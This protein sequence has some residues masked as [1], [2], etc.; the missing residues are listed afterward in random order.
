MQ[1][2]ARTHAALTSRDI[3]K[4]TTKRQ[5]CYDHVVHWGTF[6]LQVHMSSVHYI[7]S[8]TYFTWQEFLQ[9]FLYTHKNT[10][11]RTHTDIYIYT[12]IHTNKTKKQTTK[13]TNKQ[14]K[15]THTHTHTYRHAIL[16]GRMVPEL[17]CNYCATIVSLP[18]SPFTPE[19]Q[20]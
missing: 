9:I 15:T 18:L 1:G 16:L 13:Q 7:C 10:D 6:V 12:Y 5:W 3:R 17:L 19:L 4:H 2:C 20:L 11:T 14:T 8:K